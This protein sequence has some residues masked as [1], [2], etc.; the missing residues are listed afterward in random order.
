M[1][2]QITLTQEDIKNGFAGSSTS[3]PVALALRRAFPEDGIQVDGVS[4]IIGDHEIDVTDAVGY[5]IE[6][7]DSGDEPVKPFTFTVQFAER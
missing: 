6:N 4:L 2:T 5:F 3:C 7:F 1:T